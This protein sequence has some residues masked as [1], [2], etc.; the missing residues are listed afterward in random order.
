MNDSPR[1]RGGARLSE[2]VICDYDEQWSK[3][4]RLLKQVI[5][6][7]L[8][9]LI[10]KVE[11]VG[12]TAV[13]GLGAKPILD[14]DLV[15]E[16]YDVLP[17]VILGLEKIGYFHQEEWS[18]EGREA[19]GRKD[20]LTPWGGKNTKWMEHHLYVCN[21]DSNELARH[22]A[23]RDYL[24]SNPGAVAEYDR[25]KRKLVN[26]A[27]GRADYTIGKTDFITKVLE[28]EIDE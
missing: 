16:S 24:R 2:I 27:K 3:T 4:F 21:Q 13:K 7:N 22:I 20:T 17:A 6:M 12:S 11:H 28:G 14:I 18:F 25:I 19:F 1:K 5:E 8:T 10:T 9:D 26:R 23:F 15:I